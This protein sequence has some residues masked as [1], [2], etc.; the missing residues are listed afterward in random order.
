MPAMRLTMY[1]KGVTLYCVPTADDRNTWLRSMRHIAVEGRC[2]VLSACHQLKRSAYPADHDCD[3]GNDKDTIL[4]RGGSA[5]IGSMGEILSDPVF[6]EETILF[7]DID[8]DDVVRARF[9]FDAA[10]HYS[11]P[12]IFSLS[13]D[14]RPR[15]AGSSITDFD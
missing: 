5:I 4:L 7:A 13:V 8:A 2:S 10:G 11:G 12:D 15:T 1:S 3:M 9:D 6:D 14:E